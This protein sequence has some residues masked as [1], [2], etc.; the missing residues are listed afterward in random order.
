VNERYRIVPAQY[1]VNVKRVNVKQ[2]NVNRPVM[3]PMCGQARN[4]CL[5]SSF[6]VRSPVEIGVPLLRLRRGAEIDLPAVGEH[7]VNTYFVKSAV[8]MMTAGSLALP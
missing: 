5:P 1:G 3:S 4:P 7:Q 2:A 6:T 8:L